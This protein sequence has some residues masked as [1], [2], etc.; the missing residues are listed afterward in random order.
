MSE[1]VCC[2]LALRA[3]ITF[4]LHFYDLWFGVGKNL[5]GKRWLLSS[6]L[7]KFGGATQLSD[8]Y[9]NKFDDAENGCLQ[10]LD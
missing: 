2:T 8:N 4:C 7:T 1:P 5:I 9:T 6:S 10:W 3:L